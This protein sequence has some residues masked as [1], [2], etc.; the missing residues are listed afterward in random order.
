MSDASLTFR[1]SRV[2]GAL[3]GIMGGTVFAGVV[4][5]TVL[6]EMGMA[7]W[8]TKPM[9]TFSVAFSLLFGGF[10]GVFLSAVARSRGTELSIND[11]VCTVREWFGRTWSFRVVK[12]VIVQRSIALGVSSYFRLIVPVQ[13]R[14]VICI[15]CGRALTYAVVNSHTDLRELEHRLNNLAG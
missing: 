13:F 4:G 15:R 3:W 5:T 11:G 8:I 1:G 10:S 7:F 9:D 12:P 6:S 2:E 14:T